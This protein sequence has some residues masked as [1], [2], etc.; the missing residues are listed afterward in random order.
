MLRFF[1]SLFRTEE[2]IWR[3]EFFNAEHNLEQIY[4]HFG[5]EAQVRLSARSTLNYH[6]FRMTPSTICPISIKLDSIAP[7]QEAMDNFSNE[8]SYR[9]LRAMSLRAL[10]MGGFFGQSSM[11]TFNF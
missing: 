4:Y 8:R 2:Y 10:T 9:F 1:L 7:Y 6:S 11:R 3:V 5:S